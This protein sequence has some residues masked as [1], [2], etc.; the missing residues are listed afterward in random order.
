MGRD[1]TKGGKGT[2]SIHALGNR[3]RKV[4]DEQ[5]RT[6]RSEI[7]VEEWLTQDLGGAGVP[8]QQSLYATMTPGK[9]R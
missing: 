4:W 1:H 5:K 9:R 6:L 8:R 3:S 2:N 7:R